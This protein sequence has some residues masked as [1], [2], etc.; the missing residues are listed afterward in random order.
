MLKATQVGDVTEIK[1]G[2]SL[3]GE[4]AL[5]W[6]SAYLID[7]ILIDSGCDYSKNELAEFL[8]DKR[9]SVIVNTHHH[10]DH[11]GGKRPPRKAV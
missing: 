3:D 11:I 7:D 2:R 4:T 1:M 10:E 6:V 5:Y 9:V 8:Q